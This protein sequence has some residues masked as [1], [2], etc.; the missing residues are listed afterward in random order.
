MSASKTT[1]TDTQVRIRYLSRQLVAFCRGQGVPGFLG[2]RDVPSSEETGDRLAVAVEFCRWDRW[3]NRKATAEVNV[4]IDLLRKLP[5]EYVVLHVNR[6]FLVI[7]SDMCDILPP[8]GAAEPLPCEYALKEKWK[9]FEEGIEGV[10]G[11][12]RMFSMVRT[13]CSHCGALAIGSCPK[14]LKARYCGVECQEAAWSA[15]RQTCSEWKC[16]PE[17]IQADGNMIG[18]THLC[19][20]WFWVNAGEKSILFSAETGKVI[21]DKG[22]Q[23]KAAAFSLLSTKNPRK[24]ARGKCSCKD[25]VKK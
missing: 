13:Y 5:D 12:I 18:D 1:G 24:N 11:P 23:F 9:E 20:E 4:V 16:G 8:L 21:T 14:C 17:R 19:D 22:Q 3:N 6:Q 7:W 25:R 2:I 10:T 15:H